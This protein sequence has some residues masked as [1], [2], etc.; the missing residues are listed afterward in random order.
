M[1]S[2]GGHEFFSIYPDFNITRP[3]IY[4]GWVDLRRFIG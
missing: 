1:K 3:E 4:L 2:L